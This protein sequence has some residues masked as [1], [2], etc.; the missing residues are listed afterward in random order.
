MVTN[1]VV[2]A[3]GSGYSAT[4]VIT[5][6]SP[7]QQN[8]ATTF[9][10]NDGTSNAGGQPV[11]SVPLPVTKGLYA[12]LLGDTT[13][14][15]MATLPAS[16]FANNGVWL[17]VWFND[18]ITG[19]QQMMPDQR[20]AAV[21]YAIMAGS[22]PDGSITAAKI[23]A[24]AVGSS[25]LASNLTIPGT[26]SVGGLM[27]NGS[28]LSNL[29]NYQISNGTN[30]QLSAGGTFFI[31]NNSANFTLPVSANV[32]DVMRLYAPN[33]SS[34]YTFRILQNPS[35]RIV[36]WESCSASINVASSADGSHLLVDASGQFVFISTNSAV[37]WAVQPPMENWR[38]P[39]GY[40]GL[41]ISSD[42]THYYMGASFN[43][44]Q[45]SYSGILVSSDS[46][47]TWMLNTN[48][49]LTNGYNIR[50]I[51]CSTNGVKAIAASFYGG[52]YTSAD[53][54]SNW[55][56]RTGAPTN[57]YWNSVASS[58]DGAKLVAAAAYGA[59]GG[60][61]TSGN[62]GQTWTI[63][64]SAPTNAN[65]QSI[66]S[67]ADGTKLVAAVAYGAN[68]GIYTSGNSGLTWTLQA[69]A[70][71]KINWHSVD[72][73]SDGVK[74]VAGAD[75]DAYYNF[76]INAGGIYTSADSGSTWVAQTNG[77]PPYPYVYS[78]AS[79]AD[80]AKLTTSILG[81][82]STLYTSVDSGTNWSPCSTMPQ[83]TSAMIAVSSVGVSGG[84]VFNGLSNNELTLVYLGNGLFAASVGG[85]SLIGY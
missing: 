15:N 84:A 79:S 76:G 80:G 34:A 72:S 46:G 4:P 18:G 44:D 66:A 11:A 21:G 24:G 32:G 58:A 55:V 14:S 69:N 35:Q 57:A 42:S 30:I 29:G 83:N 45:G 3:P 64:T 49:G 36:K 78:V 50:T 2:T 65:W 26:M 63:Q 85:G 41:K 67:S 40:S 20:M 43:T 75:W 16:I 62:F 5:I 61:Y 51:A 38:A 19:F 68:G 33:T 48:F 23:A 54:G 77:F 53:G 56:L 10:S 1:I 8:M 59:N 13:L 71:T 7:A 39:N 9:W 6:A 74:L 31:T 22:V 73:S 25:Q 47:Q 12:V 17:R 52:I 37:S 28:P 27:V 81:Q 60:I 82:I 70:P